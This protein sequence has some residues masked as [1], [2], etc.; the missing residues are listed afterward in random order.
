MPGPLLL[1]PVTDGAPPASPGRYSLR[2]I[3]YGMEAT[4]G[5]TAVPA[6]LLVGDG[7]HVSDVARWAPTQELGLRGAVRPAGGVP[8][9][10]RSALRFE[11]E[12]DFEQVMLFLETSLG[13]ATTTGSGPYTHSYL[14]DPSAA[15][16]PRSATVQL[17]IDSGFGEIEKREFTFATTRRLT[18]EV[19]EGQTSRLA[20]ELVGRADAASAQ[21]VPTTML[22]RTPIEASDVEL[23][24]D[25]SWAALGTTPLSGALRELSLD[26][27][28]GLE[29]E[30]TLDERVGLDFSRLRW[31]RL[32]GALRFEIDHDATSAA[33]VAAW[34]AGTQRFVRLRA[35]SSTK[36]LRVDLA[37]H[38]IGRPV[39]HRDGDTESVRLSLSVDLDPTTAQMVAVQ[40]TNELAGVG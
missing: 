4:P 14:V 6:T 35:A 27:L 34:R 32:Q 39:L 30:Y 29:P 17:R 31:G 26:L 23:F 28:P 15:P 8:V 12:A 20:A 38:Y 10:G 16:Q 25:E 2:S 22:A 13:A 5:A 33:E 19:A 3:A 9:L 1:L 18:L 37:G 40:V 7:L 24:V 36:E 11:S 21:A